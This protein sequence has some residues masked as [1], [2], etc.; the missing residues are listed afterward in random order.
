M[1]SASREAPHATH[2]LLYFLGCNSFFNAKIIDANLKTLEFCKIRDRDT[3]GLVH[4]AAI[5][6]QSEPGVARTEGFALKKIL[7]PKNKIA[8]G[9]RRTRRGTIRRM[10]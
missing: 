8:R 1:Q 3:K 4:C 2:R 7:H 6:E 9:I 10:F 5:T